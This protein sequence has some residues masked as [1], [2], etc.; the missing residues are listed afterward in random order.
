[1]MGANLTIW[2][3]LVLLAV[4]L[5]LAEANAKKSA[6][7]LRWTSNSYEGVNTD[8]NFGIV[9]M[10]AKTFKEYVMARPR[11]YG[12]VVMFTS[13]DG[14]VSCQF[15]TQI[16]PEFESVAE[17]FRDQH[18][19]NS[20]LFFVQLEVASAR[21]VF[22]EL[23]LKSIPVVA[24]FPPRKNGGMD[25][26]ITENMQY[27][28]SNP[29]ADAMSRWVTEKT[30]VEFRLTK[31]RSAP[32]GQNS[33]SS[34]TTINA[35][36]FLVTFGLLAKMLHSSLPKAAQSPS[37]PMFWFAACLFIYY[38]MTS[39]TMFDIINGPP[40]VFVHP[41][42]GFRLFHWTPQQQFVL[43]G[44]LMGGLFVVGAA[45]I[46]MVTY[47]LDIVKD[48]GTRR[49]VGLGCTAGLMLVFFQIQKGYQSK[50]PG[51]SPM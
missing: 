19:R 3:L 37:A 21:S 20:K 46:V 47:L 35:I 28:I 25:T 41:S 12:T 18:E 29:S 49:M 30:K 1:M 39:G 5:P 48:N 7:M 15:C 33:A 16:Q 43:E 10:D 13:T 8:K 22:G 44:Y 24:Y 42:M 45:M 38:M 34:V 17:S 26:K 36:L 2:A 23:Q 32:A 9:K 50:Q 51:Y 11:S 31:R 27:Q 4:A 14:S 6:D 40:L